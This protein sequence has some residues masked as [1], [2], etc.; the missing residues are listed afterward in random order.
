V[1]NRTRPRSLILIIALVIIS[2]FSLLVNVLVQGPVAQGP[3]S[4]VV[5]PVQQALTE[6]G[7]VISG[8]FRSTGDLND[9]R[10]RAE[11]LQRQ[12]G[13]LEAEN[14]RLRE[15]QAS[16]EQYRNLLK[17]ANDNPS[18]SVVGADVIGI[19]DTI[20]CK[21]KLPTSPNAGKC[22]NVIAKDSSPFIR[23]VTINV[24]QR[25]GVQ[26]GMPVVGG[27][28]ALVGRVGEVSDATAQVQLLTDP[29]SFVNVRMVDTRATGTVAGTSEG[30]LVLQ[31]VPQTEEVKEGDLIV[32]SGLGGTLPQALPV[33]TVERVVSQDVE[34]SQRAIIRPGVDFD[35]LEAVL[36]ITHARQLPTPTPSP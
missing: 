14:L 20:N 28:L 30:A 4:V 24:G 19:G 29:N 35:R 6:V 13:E 36:V 18:Y 12:V 21:D 2:L 8:F 16:I 25:D 5:A 7:R 26:I 3:L 15:F 27:G 11:S 32:T 9:L 31:N 22:A 1:T 34:T 33:G 23:Y 17:F 10:T